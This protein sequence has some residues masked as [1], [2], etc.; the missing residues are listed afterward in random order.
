MLL[1]TAAITV[2]TS[3]DNV[4]FC[5]V[6]TFSVPQPPQVQNEV[7]RALVHW[8]AMRLKEISACKTPEQS[9]AHIRHSLHFGSLNY[10]YHHHRHH[11]L[12]CISMLDARPE[13]GIQI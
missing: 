10:N 9:S 2:F 12:P 13:P 4:N 11:P 1:A 5:K 8:G 7:R 6:F 3:T